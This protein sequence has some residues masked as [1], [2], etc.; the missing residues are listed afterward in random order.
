MAA[1]N[2]T[3]LLVYADG[4]LIAAQKGVTITLNQNAYDTSTKDSAGWATHGLGQRSFEVSIDGLYSTTGISA[5]ELLAYITGRTSLLLVVEGSAHNWLAEA[6]MVDVSLTGGQ[7]EAATLSGTMKANGIIYQMG[8][9][10]LTDPDLNDDATYDTFTHTASPPAV[11]S[12][13]DAGAGAVADS[14]I[15]SVTDTHVYKLVTFL[16]NTAGELPTVGIYDTSAVAYISN[17]P[18]LTAGI[19]FATLTA[20]ATEAADAF[21]RIENTAA[22]NW[23]MTTIYIWDTTP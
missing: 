9:N 18:S 2:G 17:Q 1:I 11:T 15:I 10:L 4:V 5:A 12:A 20:T 3:I 13:I 19:N 7:E 23:Q 14:N 21:L 22:C 16:T 6:D 8:T